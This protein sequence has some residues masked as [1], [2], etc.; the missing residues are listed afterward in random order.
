M[1]ITKF[2]KYVGEPA[3]AIDLEE[4]VKRLGNFLLQSG[5]ESQ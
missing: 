4:L 3:E 1:K 2:S 5:F